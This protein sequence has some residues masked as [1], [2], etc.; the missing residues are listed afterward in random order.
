[1]APILHEVDLKTFRDDASLRE[2]VFG[3]A[4]V[5]VRASL[6]TVPDCLALLGGQLTT[7]VHAVDDDITNPHVSRLLR[8]VLSTA[9]SNSGRI[10]WNGVPTG[11][12]VTAQMQ[13]GGPYP[14]ASH[15]A[16]TSVGARSLWRWTRPVFLQGLPDAALTLLG[17]ESNLE[18]EQ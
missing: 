4:V 5:I 8:A 6:E 1:V 12:A 16:A 11:V 10:V 17:V 7:T 14:A 9:L 18:E 13:H 15:P 3:P 2:E